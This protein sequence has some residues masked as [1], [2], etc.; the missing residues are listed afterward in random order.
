[1]EDGFLFWYFPKKEKKSVVEDRFTDS[2]MGEFEQIQEMMNT[3]KKS[4]KKLSEAG[5]LSLMDVTL[6]TGSTY[7]G[8]LHCIALTSTVITGREGGKSKKGG[9]ARYIMHASEQDYWD[10]ISAIKGTIDKIRE[11]LFSEE[12]TVKIVPV[13]GELSWHRNGKSGKKEKVL[14]VLQGQ[15]FKLFSA[16]GQKEISCVNVMHSSAKIFPDEKLFGFQIHNPMC[17]LVLSAK[18]SALMLQ[19]MSNFHQA[20][21]CLMREQ[22]QYNLSPSKSEDGDNKSDFSLNPKVNELLKI[23]GNNVCADC[24]ATDP[25]W[26]SINLG[27]FI[28]LRCSGIHRKLG[29]HVSQVRSITMD[30]LSEEMLE[31]LQSVGN[32]SSNNIFLKNLPAH[33]ALPTK[34]VSMEFRQVFIT[35]KYVQKLYC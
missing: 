26:V 12:V 28:C 33:V 6:S 5:R 13:K 25:I 8:S 30:K 7:R 23:E 24:G 2:T 10:W 16:D 14:A 18:T 34:E 3:E 15:N 29:V 1:M 4:E 22:L 11:K 20:Q 21:T 35:D 9:V 27:I 32:I 31:R 19:W 17:Q